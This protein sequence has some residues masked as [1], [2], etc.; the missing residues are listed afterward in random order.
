MSNSKRKIISA[1]G[2]CLCVILLWAGAYLV[3]ELNTS[4]E[5]AQKE[6]KE[7]TQ[8]ALSYDDAEKEVVFWYSDADCAA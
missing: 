3:P 1:A 5:K 6:K 7:H 4:E 8:Q 2:L